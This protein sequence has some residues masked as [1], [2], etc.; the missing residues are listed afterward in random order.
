[1]AGCR[2]VNQNVT[3]AVTKITTLSQ[4][5]KTAG[6]EFVKNLNSAIA[7]ME[8]E[9]KDALKTFIDGDVNTYVVTDL[10]GAIKGM[11]DLLE[12]NRSNFESV[13]KQ[14]ANSISGK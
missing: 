9:A 2:I 1:M 3:D 7:E 5:Y 14:I 10:P 8:G 6:E 11:S 12:A 13:D 4:S